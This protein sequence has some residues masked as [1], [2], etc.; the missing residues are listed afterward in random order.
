LKPKKGDSTQ[1]QNNLKQKEQQRTSKFNELKNVCVEIA[2]NDQL[3]QALQMDKQ[4]IEAEIK[5]LNQSKGVKENELKTTENAS[6]KA[7]SDIEMAHSKF[8]SVS[9]GS[10]KTIKKIN[11]A[12]VKGQGVQ[13]NANIQEQNIKNSS[14]ISIEVEKEIKSMETNLSQL[15]EKI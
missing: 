15:N 13:N 2:K 5:R 9:T 12:K 10:Y 3:I 1:Y 7:H 8:S 6:K 14:P 11:G 4:Q